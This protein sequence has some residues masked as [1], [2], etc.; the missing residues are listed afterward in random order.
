MINK[1]INIFTLEIEA[2]LKVKQGTVVHRMFAF[3]FPA[4]TKHPP[5]VGT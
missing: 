5:L 3:K 2:V 4:E 1:Y